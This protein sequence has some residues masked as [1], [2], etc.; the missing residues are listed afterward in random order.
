MAHGGS[1]AGAGRKPGSKNKRDVNWNGPLVADP[2]SVGVSDTSRP[3]PLTGMTEQELTTA[4][5]LTF[6]TRVYRNRGL[7]PSVRADAAKAAL[8][9]AHARLAPPKDDQP[10]LPGIGDVRNEW[11]DDLPP[12]SM[13]N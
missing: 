7:A 8:P 2:A 1:R 3:D 4:S 12:V 9:Y 6:L 10:G 13:R 11:G 5:P